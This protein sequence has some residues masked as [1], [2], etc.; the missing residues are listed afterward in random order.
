MYGCRS[1]YGGSGSSSSSYTSRSSGS[2]VQGS[3]G[4][5]RIAYSASALTGDHAGTYIQFPRIMPTSPISLKDLSS[6]SPHSSS[7][8]PYNQVTGGDHH[9]HNYS[10]SS[11]V[12]YEL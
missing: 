8:R 5:E 7:S 4:L 12:H 1:N 2:F 10:S 3:S 11:K 6:H 9:E